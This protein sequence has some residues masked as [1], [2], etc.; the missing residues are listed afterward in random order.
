MNLEKITVRKLF[1]LDPKSFDK[2]HFTLKNLLPKS[3]IKGIQGK[4]LFDISFANV[5]WLKQ[6]IHN[7]TFENFVKAYEIVFDLDKTEFLKCDV[8]EFYQSFNWL[9]NEII[10]LIE[11]E[12]V[13]DSKPTQEQIDAGIKMFDVLGE[14]N[15]L[16]RIAKDFSV[17]SPE[18]VAKEWTYG[19][20]FLAMYDYKLNKDYNSNWEEIQ[21]RKNGNS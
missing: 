1:L 3:E 9:Q 21:K 18:K 2:Y 15:T 20:V 12:K 5:S 4:G 14:G 11:S 13:L 19:E 16:L 7:T 10:D 6:F 17:G 8:V